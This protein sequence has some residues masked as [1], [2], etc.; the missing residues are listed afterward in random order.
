MAHGM[1]VTSLNGFNPTQALI[2][3]SFKN[4]SA[5]GWMAGVG[6]LKMIQSGTY[7]R[8][9]QSVYDK[10]DKDE[11]RESVKNAVS[12]E[13]IF[14][15]KSAEDLKNSTESALYGKGGQFEALF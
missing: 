1:D 10:Q 4:S 5:A 13:S 7:K 15:K 3:N 8:T 2:N 14:D 6:D 9:L 11:V 12:P